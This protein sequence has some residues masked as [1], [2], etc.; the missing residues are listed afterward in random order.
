MVWLIHSAIVFEERLKKHGLKE[1][2]TQK[3]I[4]KRG[5]ETQ[6][7]QWLAKIM[8]LKLNLTTG[9]LATKDGVLSSI[10]DNGWLPF[11][12]CVSAI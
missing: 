7:A 6:H 11:S 12:L 8:F 10:G 4:E 3:Y 1:T 9:Y 2:E 5:V